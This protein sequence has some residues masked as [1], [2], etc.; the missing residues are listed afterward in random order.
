ML[1]FF[2]H[3][4]IQAQHAVQKGFLVRQAALE[5]A[6]AVVGR[7]PRSGCGAR[8]PPRQLWST[9]GVD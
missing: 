4:A 1:E 2:L 5:P 6:D 8:T 3:L 9:W 7:L